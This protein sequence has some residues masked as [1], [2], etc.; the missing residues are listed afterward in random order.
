MCMSSSV[1]AKYREL[2]VESQPIS[3]V[4]LNVL[5]ELATAFVADCS[6]PPT[7]S[8]YIVVLVAVTT[9]AANVHCPLG[10]TSPEFQLY[11]DAELFHV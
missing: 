5:A 11:V 4:P 9:S 1:P 10:T 6:V 8:M 7:G 2:L 3:D